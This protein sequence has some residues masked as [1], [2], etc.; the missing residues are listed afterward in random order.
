MTQHKHHSENILLS[1]VQVLLAEK[2]TYFS[3]LRTGIAL[4]SVSL[5][6]IVFLVVTSPYHEL[7]DGGLWG[8]VVVAALLT[9][10]GGGLGILFWAQ[11]KIHKLSKLT[12]KIEQ[13]NKRV[14]EIVV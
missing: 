2:R 11:G 4:I 9:L 13:E 8:F 10:A 5:S 3:I 14:D 12:K 7:F 1:E 6:I